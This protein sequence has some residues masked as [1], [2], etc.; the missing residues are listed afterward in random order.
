MMII[1]P[2][3]ARITHFGFTSSPE[4]LL[5]GLVPQQIFEAFGG[6][7]TLQGEPMNG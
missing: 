2:P 6:F 4:V 3:H 7:G 5:P 1:S